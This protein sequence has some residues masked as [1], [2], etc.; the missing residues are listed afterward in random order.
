MLWCKPFVRS[1]LIPTELLKDSEAARHVTPNMP[2]WLKDYFE[3]K[4]LE[5]QQKKG[6]HPDLHLL[7]WEREGIPHVKDA[8]T[9]PK[10]TLWPADDMVGAEG[11]GRSPV[12][13]APHVLRL[14]LHD[15]VSAHPVGEPGAS[16]VSG[17]A[18]PAE[19]PGQ[20]P[21]CTLSSC[22]SVCASL[23]LRPSSHPEGVESCLPYSANLIING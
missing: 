7:S 18:W 14:R 3:P 15:S 2:L 19:P 1:L 10:D 17:S 6:G 20:A 4:V 8:L 22:S 13:A 5:E 12:A 11:W 21:I 16:H 9:M 23:T